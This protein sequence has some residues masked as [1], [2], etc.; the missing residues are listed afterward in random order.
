M[1]CAISHPYLYWKGDR[2]AWSRCFK[3]SF[4]CLQQSAL[5]FNVEQ[6]VVA[7]VYGGNQPA[8]GTG[9][10]YGPRTIFH[11]PWCRVWILDGLYDER[12]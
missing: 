8:R 5:L 3:V 9:V 6:H 10:T 11:R 7:T 1:F 2:W 12:K 4:N